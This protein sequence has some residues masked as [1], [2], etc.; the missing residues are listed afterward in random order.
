MRERAERG[1]RERIISGEFAPGDR[2]VEREL[3][4]LLG[5]SR[6]PVREALARLENQGFVLPGRGA[7]VREMSVQD[8]EE[9][10]DL[11]VEIDR[12]AAR[13]A[14]GRVAAGGSDPLAAAMCDAERATAEGDAE[15]ILSANSAF[16][17]ALLH[18]SGN[19]LLELV[20]APLT[21]RTR[22]LFAITADRDPYEQQREHQAI[23]DAVAAGQVELAGLLAAAHVEAGRAPSVRL[24][25]A[26]TARAE[27]RTNPDEED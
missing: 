21:A 11:R 17:D 16:H 27:D 25:A 15:R 12:L 20:S 13:R 6:I 1:I 10:F 24:L 4:E 8:I 5:I 26:R 9:L 3:S 2:L 19:S 23:H 14:A 22:W 7:V 18:G